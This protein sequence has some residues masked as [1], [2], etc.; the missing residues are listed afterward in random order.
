MSNISAVFLTVCFNL[1]GILFNRLSVLILFQ[2][3]NSQLYF[4]FLVL[5]FLMSFPH[6]SHTHWHIYLMPFSVCSWLKTSTTSLPVS[7]FHVNIDF[8]FCLCPFWP[9]L[10]LQYCRS[11]VFFCLCLCPSSFFCLETA[12]E[13]CSH[14]YDDT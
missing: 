11:H 7:F 9:W 14:L 4:Q 2:N 10:S 1:I 13:K 3:A 8:S 12:L 5:H 6:L